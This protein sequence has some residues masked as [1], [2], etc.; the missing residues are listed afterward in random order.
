[1]EQ[2]YWLGRKRASLKSAA[3]AASSE[4]R[5]IHFDLAGRYSVKAAT[6]SLR[7]VDLVDSLPPPIFAIMPRAAATESDDA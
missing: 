5:L 3:D 6:A 4:A 7:A 1:M 2:T